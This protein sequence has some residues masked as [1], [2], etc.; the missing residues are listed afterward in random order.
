M[1]EWRKNKNQ[2]VV[3]FHAPMLSSVLLP[4]LLFANDWF[5]IPI[6]TNAIKKRRMKSPLQHIYTKNYTE[7]WMYTILYLWYHIPFLF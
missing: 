6:K 1:T 2:K 3:G 5:S 7:N 4:F